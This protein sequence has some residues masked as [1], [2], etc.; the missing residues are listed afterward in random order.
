MLKKLGTPCDVLNFIMSNKSVSC[1]CTILG[2]LD[3]AS[4]AAVPAVEYADCSCNVLQ[5]L[6]SSCNHGT[7]SYKNLAQGF[8]AVA[9]CTST[10]ISES[11]VLSITGGNPFAAIATTLT[12]EPIIDG[13]IYALQNYINS[14]DPLPTKGLCD[15]A[16]ILGFEI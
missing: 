6:V 15:S 12:I 8:F 14:D 4:T 13:G 2:I 1:G 16:K 5:T 7:L 9:D 3:V 11:L 10:N